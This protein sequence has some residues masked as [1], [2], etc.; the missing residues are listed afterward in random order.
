MHYL[1]NNNIMNKHFA[2]G[3]IK[4]MIFACMIIW[5]I[6]KVAT[7]FSQVA[8]PPN[9][10]KKLSDS[11]IQYITPLEYAF[12]MHEETSWLFKTDI[13]Y[14]YGRFYGKIGIEKRIAPSFTLNLKVDQ[15]IYD[16]VSGDRT[17]G[18]ISTSLESRWYYRL[19]KRVRINKVARNMSDNYFA[20]GLDYTRLFKNKDLDHWAFTDYNYLTLFLKWGL[21]RR[22]LKYGHADVGIKIGATNA[23]GDFYSTELAFATYVDLGLAFTKDRYKL[24]REKLCPVMKCYES[25]NHILKSN[26][27]NL[28]NININRHYLGISISPHIAFER[29]IGDAPFSFNTEI[30]A[31]YGYSKYKGNDEVLYSNWNWNAEIM[32]EGRWYYNLK[33]RILKGKTGNGLSANYVALGGSYKY[34]RAEYYDQGYFMPDVYVSV[35]WQRVFGKHF[36]F[37]VSFGIE[38]NFEVQNSKGYIIQSKGLEPRF[39]IAVGYRF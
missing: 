30:Q 23:I 17:S 7:V 27:S 37:D 13:S 10:S 16:D 19:N 4:L 34:E 33:R 36:Y 8:S 32:L 24:D 11:T 3:R 5:M 21:Q 35:G 6:F 22:F 38:Y 2:S 25:T 9:T 29:K 31:R 14:N 15:N 12:M 39:K 20:F 18:G 28:F 26:L 1:R